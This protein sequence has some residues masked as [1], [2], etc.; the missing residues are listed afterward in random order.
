MHES[1]TLKWREVVD[2]YHCTLVDELTVSLDS[3]FAAERQAENLRLAAERERVKLATAESLNQILRRIRQASSDTAVLKMLAEATSAYAQRVVLVSIEINSVEINSIE[4]NH[5][6]NTHNEN[7]AA[8]VVARRDAGEGDLMFDVSGAAAVAAV[9]DTKDPVVAL[10]SASQIPPALVDA[11]AVNGGKVYLFP[12][13]SRQEVVAILLAAGTVYAPA[14]ELL[15]GTAGLTMEI[16]A[17]RPPVLKALP[18]YGLPTQDFVQIAGPALPTA[19]APPS[20]TTG[21]PRT[22]RDLTAEDQKLHLQAQR[23]ARVKVAEM[24]LYHA[25]ELRNGVASG[26]IYK[27]LHTEI[28]NARSAFLQAFLSKSTT[29]VDYLHLELLRSLA[30]DDDRLLG[31]DYPGP[32]V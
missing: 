29:M 16:L 13:I 30:H 25:E 6:G 15:S 28:D 3:V 24:R 17:P 21:E 4:I 2:K 9:I 22:W 5:T 31:E 18:S 23:V 8:R 19:A 27:A 14:L 12:L 7:I 11:L 26:S 32:M 20:S 10:A 1:P